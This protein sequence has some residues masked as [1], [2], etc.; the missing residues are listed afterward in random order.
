MTAEVHT[1]NNLVCHELLIPEDDYFVLKKIPEAAVP[2]ALASTFEVLS[3][4]HAEDR[5]DTKEG[6]VKGEQ[7]GC[8][9]MVWVQSIREDTADNSGIMD[10]SRRLVSD[11]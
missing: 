5:L 8:I 6:R 10:V 4:R 2:E 7:Y 3:C 9:R 1:C 11:R